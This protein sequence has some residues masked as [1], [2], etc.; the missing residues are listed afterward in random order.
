MIYTSSR[1]YFHIKN[2]IS[3]SFNR[4]NTVLDRAS[5]SG[6]HRVLGVNVL[7]HR[8]QCSLDGG[9]ISD[10]R[11]GSLAIRT[12]EGVRMFSGR[13]ITCQG[14]GLDWISAEPVPAQSRPI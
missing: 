11:R 13:W 4:F 9:L 3:N 5:F 1:V 14:H 12:R 6:K 8:A 10:K 7:R 2:P